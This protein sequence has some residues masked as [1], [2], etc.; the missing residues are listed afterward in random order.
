MRE[1]RP[2]GVEFLRFSE[3]GN[4]ANAVL[5]MRTVKNANNFI[6]LTVNDTVSN[7][8][9]KCKVV[10][11]VISLWY[12]D[13]ASNVWGDIA[14]NPYDTTF[15][16]KV[17]TIWERKVTAGLKIRFGNQGRWY[18]LTGSYAIDESITL[19]EQL[20]DLDGD[21]T[22]DEVAVEFDVTQRPVS[23]LNSVTVLPRGT[24]IDLQHSGHE[25]GNVPFAYVSGNFKS[26]VIMFSP[27]GYVD[28][29]YVD[30][31]ES[32]PF[33]GVS[34]FLVGEWDKI[35][36]SEADKITLGGEDKNNVETE[37]N[38][39]VTVKDRDGTVRISGNAPIVDN[40]ALPDDERKALRLREAR[41]FARSDLH[42]NIGGL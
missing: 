29:L 2:C 39:W 10:N 23:T 18:N 35:I 9:I 8:T 28:R 11:G 37:S 36:P 32:V 21:G 13:D 1:N 30:G 14:S 40:T 41:G 38:F 3:T 34:Y 20:I 6:Q 22:P 31:V 7:K 15:E 26:V 33:N 25:Q 5:Q 19:P 17:R 4:E 12:Y 42:N 27:A 24:I 16:A